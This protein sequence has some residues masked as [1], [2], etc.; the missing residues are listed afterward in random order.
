MG[1][2]I[3][4]VMTAFQAVSAPRGKLTS[5]AFSGIGG[6]KRGILRA[7]VGGLMLGLPGE[8]V[9]GFIGGTIGEKAAGLDDSAR[10]IVDRN[11]H[12]NFGGN[13]QNTKQAY[14]M[15][16][17][18]VME[19]VAE[20]AHCQVAPGPGSSALPIPG[21]LVPNPIVIHLCAELD[22]DNTQLAVLYEK[23][24]GLQRALQSAAKHCA[25]RSDEGIGPDRF[26][27]RPHQH[28][29]EWKS[30]EDW[31]GEAAHPK[32]E[33]APQCLPFEAARDYV[34]SLSLRSTHDWLRLGHSGKLLTNIPA[35]PQMVYDD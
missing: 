2:D 16:Q 28:Y 31:L 24:A 34:R 1:L 14:T 4:G 32:I 26:H 9:G 15:R 27:K 18:A 11:H 17:L 8:V 19:N 22:S 21:V 10:A 29:N 25:T 30:W 12:L 20:H 6:T 7:A 5:V 35:M 13:F 3:G 23:R 33:A